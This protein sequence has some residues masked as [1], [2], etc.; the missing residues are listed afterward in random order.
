MFPELVERDA[1]LAPV[2][3]KLKEEH[4]VIARLLTRLDL[5]CVEL[6]TLGQAVTDAGPHPAESGLE[7]VREE[8]ERLATVLSSHF[9]YEE[10]EL[11]EP[12]ARLDLRI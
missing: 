8:V 6:I 3:E 4:E 9:A 10:E 7:R 5:A 1:E 11:V 2:I 12:I